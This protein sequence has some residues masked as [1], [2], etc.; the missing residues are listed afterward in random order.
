MQDKLEHGI[1]EMVGND[2][3]DIAQV[4]IFTGGPMCL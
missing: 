3:G 1:I 2:W 4:F